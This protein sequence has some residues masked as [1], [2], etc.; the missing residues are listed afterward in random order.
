MGI[1]QKY[2][3]PKEIDF[4]R[5]LKKQ[6]NAS[7]NC[8]HALCLFCQKNDRNAL[9]AILEN[10]HQSRALKRKNMDELLDVFITPY[11]KESIYRIITQLDWIALSV[12]HLAIELLSYKVTCPDYYENIFKTLTEMVDALDEAFDYLPQK[13]LG[14]ILTNIETIH[15]NYDETT[16]YCALAAVKHL[17][18]DEAKVY[19]AHKEILNQLKE[20]SK[21]IYISANTLEDMAMKII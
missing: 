9:K 14:K 17:N 12:K 3:L 21:R 18:E 11:D 16:R 15:D 6:V 13:K 19:F 4:N 10:E 2:L 5:A 8:V 20:V 1:I 7:R